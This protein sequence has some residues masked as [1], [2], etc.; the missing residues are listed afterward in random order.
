MKIPF[1]IQVEKFSDIMLELPGMFAEQYGELV[2]DKDGLKEDPD[3]A[4]YVGLENLGVLHCVTARA[5]GNL[6]GYFINMVVYH[7][8]HKGLKTSTSE[9]L[10]V[11]PQYRKG[12]GIGL[13]LIQNTLA[14]L[15]K[16][17]V[18][19][20]YVIAKKGTKLSKVLNKL[21]FRH[22]E[23]VYSLWLGE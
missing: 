23:E 10:Y 15:E 14:E 7:L 18:Q 20:V 6:V 4:R 9:L 5:Y 11:L 21:D 13:A 16:M 17:G 12:T 8:H 19:K 3:Y 2:A 22:I 1:T